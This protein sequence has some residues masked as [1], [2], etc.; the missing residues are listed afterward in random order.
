[1]CFLNFVRRYSDQGA[2]YFDVESHSKRLLCMLNSHRMRDT[3]SYIFYISYSQDYYS[4]L[5]RANPDE[6]AI[7]L[8]NA[9]VIYI[10][11][12]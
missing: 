2:K 8:A 5:M 3:T 7:S 11:F 9:N 4:N 10:L 12:R 1:M 6:Y